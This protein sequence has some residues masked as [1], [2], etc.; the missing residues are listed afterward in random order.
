MLLNVIANRDNWELR[1]KVTLFDIFKQLMLH[2]ILEM[3]KTSG[4]ITNSVP[5]L[6][7]LLGKLI[8]MF[9]LI[10]RL[11]VKLDGEIKTDENVLVSFICKLI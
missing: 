11:L 2:V 5:E 8:V 3:S 10:I 9:K 7:P 4:K 6:I 1:L